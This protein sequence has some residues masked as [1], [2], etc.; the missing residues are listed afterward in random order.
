[1]EK[2]ILAYIQSKKLIQAGDTVVIGVSG[3]PD[4]LCLLYVL[5]A[6]KS[7]LFFHI[8]CAHLNHQAREEAD[9]DEAFVSEVC[10]KLSVPFEYARFDMKVL[11]K[12]RKENFHQ[13]AREYRYRFFLQI[14]KKYRAKKIA[15]AHHIEDLAETFFMR[16]VKNLP[17]EKWAA[18]EAKQDFFQKQL[19]RPLLFLKKEEL[20]AYLHNK[21]YSYRIDASNDADFYTRNRFRKFLMPFVY[22]ENPGFFTKFLQIQEEIRADECYL[23]EQTKNIYPQIVIWQNTQEVILDTEK[24]S[25]LPFSLQRRLIRVVLEY[26]YFSVDA[27]FAS[28]HIRQV[29]H[30]FTKKEGYRQIHLSRGLFAS[31]SYKKG[32]IGYGK[33]KSATQYMLCISGEGVYD[34]PNGAQMVVTKETDFSTFS[35]GSVD[36]FC[37]QDAMVAFPYFVRTREPGDLI[38]LETGNHKKISRLFI[39]QKVPQPKRDGWPLFCNQENH[40]LWVP[41][42]RNVAPNKRWVQKELFFYRFQ[43]RNGICLEE[44]E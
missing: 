30:L 15:T 24:F 8:V 33:E 1:M 7:Q 17:Y 4:S 32:R 40:I 27:F 28:H 42:L 36:C 21:A 25:R 16:I 10:Q 43:Y 22:Q 18:F 34:L 23:M 14:A 13:I 44:Q 12:E 6:L 41:G 26:L 2:R 29:L 20:I 9:T 38:Q 37:I 19:I 3:G 35:N 31:I 39:D 5:H 11:S